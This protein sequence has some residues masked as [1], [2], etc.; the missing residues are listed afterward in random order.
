MLLKGK[1]GAA[2]LHGQTECDPVV[3]CYRPDPD[4]FPES[5]FFLSQEKCMGLKIQSPPSPSQFCTR[6]EYLCLQ[7]VLLLNHMIESSTDAGQTINFGK[8][9]VFGL[10]DEVSLQNSFTKILLLS[11]CWT[12]FS[13]FRWLPHLSQFKKPKWIV[14]KY[15]QSPWSQ[16]NALLRANQNTQIPP[17]ALNFAKANKT[18]LP[19]NNLRVSFWWFKITNKRYL[20]IPANKTGIVVALAGCYFP[21][22]LFCSSD[23]ITGTI[24]FF[25]FQH[26]PHM[27]SATY[28]NPLHKDVKSR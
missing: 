14:I 22:C 23:L 25:P 15:D 13:V 21:R 11:P 1:C 2:N 17:L 7:P 18:R 3:L 16:S 5:P 4:K 8:P 10:Q 26:F 9:N 27:L 19:P 24:P 20:L 6:G 12:F 28:W